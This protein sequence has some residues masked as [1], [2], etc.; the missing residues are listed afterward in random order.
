MGISRK[1]MSK[2]SASI[3]V[4]ANQY[5]VRVFGPV[6]EQ[7]LDEDDEEGNAS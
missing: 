6:E 2:V 5:Q 4:I 1:A 7:T 3:P